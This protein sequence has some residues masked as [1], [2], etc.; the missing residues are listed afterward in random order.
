MTAKRNVKWGAIGFYRV[1]HLE[2]VNWEIASRQTLDWHF[3]KLRLSYAV[4][5]LPS[6]PLKVIGSSRTVN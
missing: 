4:L 1:P 5:F 2:E 6:T 3:D